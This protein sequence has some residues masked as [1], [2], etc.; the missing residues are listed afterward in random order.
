VRYFL[1]L[2]LL[3]GCDLSGEFLFSGA[4]NGVPGVLIVETADGDTLHEPA[5]VT[6]YDAVKENTIYFEVGPTGT[7]AF[8]GA[9]LDFIGTGGPVCVWVDP[10]LATWNQAIRESL[11][12]FLRPFS[13]PDNIFDDGDIDVTGGRSVFYTG[14]P[15]VEMGDFVLQYED[16]LGNDVPVE[17]VECRPTGS[18][19]G[20]INPFAGRSTAEFCEFSNTDVGVSYTVAMNTWS[21]PL[22]DDRLGVAVLLA[23]GSCDSMVDYAGNDLEF[24]PGVIDARAI[25]CVLRGESIKPDG[26]AEVLYGFEAAEAAAWEGSIEFEET[27]CDV[28]GLWRLDEFCENEAAGLRGLTEDEVDELLDADDFDEAAA[29]AGYEFTE[30][31]LEEFT[32][33]WQGEPTEEDRCFCGDPRDTPQQ[34][35]G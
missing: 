20:A 13:Y 7:A 5:V 34:G 14:S 8:G 24:G 35:A 1:P 27:F 2:V 12:P 17:F 23:A 29:A 10:E 32:C 26:E 15:G 19:L 6:N 3:A 25:E 28:Q 9:T 11:D 16:E 33:E 21:T 30:E 22:D 4:V 31:S 18:E